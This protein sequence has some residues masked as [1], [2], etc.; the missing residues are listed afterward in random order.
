M[1]ALQLTWDRLRAVNAASPDLIYTLAAVALTIVAVATIPDPDPGS[2]FKE[3]DGIATALV[4]MQTAVIAFLRRWPLAVLITLVAT[5]ITEAAIGYEIGDVAFLSSLV[6]VFVVASRITGLKAVLGAGLTIGVIT[7]LFFLE[8][9]GVESVVDLV[10]SFAIF[11]TAWAGGV[12]VRNRVVRIAQV[13]SYAA[14]LSLQR[15]AAAQEAAADERARIARE[16]H[17]AVGHTLNLIVVQAGAAQRVRESNPAAAYDALRSI[18]NTGRQ[19][20]TDMDRMLGILREQSYGQAATDLGPR[21]GLSLLEPMLNEARTAGLKV[22]LEVTGEARKLPVSMDLTAYRIIQEA[23]TNVIKHAPGADVAV[24]IEHAPRML[25][26]EVR[27]GP[28]RDGAARAKSGGGRG[29]P[30]M[31]ERVALFG[32]SIQSAAVPGGGF[33]LQVSLPVDGAA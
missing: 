25:K 8:G 33:L 16:L 6:I 23:I 21:P 31:K 28:P 4:V 5:L 1:H 19:A 32:G 27:N 20:L 15:E 26:L 24:K 11:A 14:E 9:G 22:T 13:E 2:G 30:G 12:F 29:L 7:A 17:D 18:E 10:V 3:P